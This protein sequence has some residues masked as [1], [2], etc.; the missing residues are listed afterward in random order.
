MNEIKKRLGSYL[1]VNRKTKKE[2]AQCLG[3]APSALCNKLSGR[4]D[5]TLSEGAKLSRLFNCALDDLV[6]KAPTRN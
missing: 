5:F 3:I 4:S 1:L 2:V 6:D